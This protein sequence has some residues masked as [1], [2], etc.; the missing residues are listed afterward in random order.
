MI[1]VIFNTWNASNYY[2]VKTH[3]QLMWGFCTTMWDQSTRFRRLKRTAMETLLAIVRAVRRTAWNLGFFFKCSINYSWHVNPDSASKE[4][5]G[6]C[7]PN[8]NQPSSSYLS[9]IGLSLGNISAIFIGYCFFHVILHYNLLFMGDHI[10]KTNLFLVIFAL[11]YFI[12][13]IT[14]QDNS[15][16]SKHK[17]CL[18]NTYDRICQKTQ[19]C[20]DFIGAGTGITGHRKSSRLLIFNATGD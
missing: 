18:M 20:S 1:G 12:F 5:K 14:F 8:F 9:L 16:F 7:K 3:Q 19:S 6:I 4:A 15:I 11:I 13:V 17:F 2:S 10:G